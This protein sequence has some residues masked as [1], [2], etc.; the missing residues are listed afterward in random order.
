[1]ST[2][3]AEQVTCLVK[4][5]FSRPVHALKLT[6][7]AGQAS[8][9]EYYRVEADG[10]S[11][12]LMK[13]PPGRS[14][15]SEEVTHLT[16]NFPELPFVNVQKFLQEQNLPCPQIYAHDPEAGLL[17]LQDLGDRSLETVLQQSN[18]VLKIFFYQQAIT[19]LVQLQQKT[20][21]NS[22]HCMAYF[23]QFDEKLLQWECDHFLEYGIE[24]RLGCTVTPD[25]K[26]IFRQMSQQLV[27]EILTM[28]YGFV[29]RD[30]QSRNLLIHDYQ[31]WMIDFQ[32]AL[33]G[34]LIYDLVSLVRDSYVVLLPQQVDQLLLF[35]AG[36]LDQN[37]PYCGRMDEI[38]RH[39]DLVTIQRKLKDAGRFQYI[40]TVKKNPDFLRCVEPS[41]SY[42]RQAFRQQKEYRELGRVIGRYLTTFNI[43]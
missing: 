40:L 16:K 30:F 9:R 28:P 1:M 8:Y 31:T 12:I 26:N 4:K 36:A 11:T 22:D 37:H 32:D 15:A 41:L 25:D 38:K 17:L 35:Y 5:A 2:T 27:Q 39:F 14:S 19:L 7:L 43:Q 13:M 18:D 34:P 42:V 21:K 29:H 10:T 23:R 6:K 24:D 33:K 3:L 20:R